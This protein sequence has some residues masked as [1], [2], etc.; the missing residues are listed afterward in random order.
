CGNDRAY[1]WPH[2]DRTGGEQGHAILDTGTCVKRGGFVA[3]GFGIP[4]NEFTLGTTLIV[5]GTTALTG[6]LI[7]I[8]LAANKPTLSWVL[9]L[10]LS[11]AGFTAIGF[12]IPI[13]EFT[14]GTTLIVEGT[15]A[16]VG[17]LTLAVNSASAP[18]GADHGGQFVRRP[19][20]RSELVEASP[21]RGRVP[22]PPRRPSSAQPQP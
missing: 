4:I 8:G 9:G 5:A 19:H 2:S 10:A 15:L 3:I 12:G 14:L 18:A 22:E 7:Q 21:P 20:R 17:G 11:A 6:G 13:H 1:R 16:A